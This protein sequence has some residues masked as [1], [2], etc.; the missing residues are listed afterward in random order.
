MGEC[1][2]ELWCAALAATMTAITTTPVLEKVLTATASSTG[3]KHTHTHA[4]HTRRRAA[5]HTAT[6][7]QGGVLNTW[8][9]APTHPHGNAGGRHEGVVGFQSSGSTAGRRRVGTAAPATT[10]TTAINAG[11]RT[12]NTRGRQK[13]KRHDRGKTWSHGRRKPRTGRGRHREAPRVAPRGSPHY[14]H[15]NCSCCILTSCE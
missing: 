12:T 15:S 1:C 6:C 13:G 9:L 14:H 3:T 2:G 11:V 7:A 8:P 5:G 10:T 4:R